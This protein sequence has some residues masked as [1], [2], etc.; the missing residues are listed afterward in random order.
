MRERSAGESNRKL[1]DVVKSLR[2]FEEVSDLKIAKQRVLA[3]GVDTQGGRN[4]LYW[5]K[6][7]VVLAGKK[8]RISEGVVSGIVEKKLSYKDVRKEF[9]EEIT[10]DPM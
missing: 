6:N 8:F 2:S 5:A 3:A 10:R 4:V 7:L 9:C 1:G